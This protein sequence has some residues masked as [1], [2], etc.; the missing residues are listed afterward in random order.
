MQYN[1]FMCAY[2][3]HFFTHRAIVQT[4]YSNLSKFNEDIINESLENFDID[5]I[6]VNIYKEKMGK[7]LLEWDALNV[8]VK[9]FEEGYSG[10]TRCAKS[11][12]F[13]AIVELDDC[14][15]PK[16][17]N[18]KIINDSLEIAK[19]FCPSEMK[20]INKILDFYCNKI[21]AEKESIPLSE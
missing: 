18:S 3:L 20:I 11:V 13:A 4:I 5:E 6:D 1:Q 9:K 2:R 19:V 21:T 7:I 12:L 15:V 14:S 8:I 17:T 10:L 16:N